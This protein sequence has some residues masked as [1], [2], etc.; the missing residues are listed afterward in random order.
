MT[1]DLP[2][3]LAA[4]DFQNPID[5]SLQ[6]SGEPIEP[7][8]GD[9]I[10][11]TLK[12]MPENATVM[13]SSSEINPQM[14]EENVT[15]TWKNYTSPKHGLSIEYPDGATIIEGRE[16]PYDPYKDLKILDDN[17]GF[18]FAVIDLNVMPSELEQFAGN[19]LDEKINSYDYET[20]II[21]IQ[22]I[23]PLSVNNRTYYTFIDSTIDRETD[24]SRGVQLNYFVSNGDRTYNFY[25]TVITEKMDST[26]EIRD[27]MIESIE[28][29]HQNPLDY[30]NS[31]A[32]SISSTDD[33]IVR[34]YVVN[35][36][37]PGKDSII[38]HCELMNKGG[39]NIPPKDCMYEYYDLMIPDYKQEIFK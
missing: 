24:K 28:F 5:P 36:D 21:P 18:S 4:D 30:L 39:L 17:S 8:N 7:S 34:D 10:N 31:T 2:E 20:Y 32:T 19:L 33:N 6:W 12:S 9:F 13:T 29:I 11:G 25:F 14:L 3:N 35:D 38:G 22:D 15:I 37:N 16:S 27:H 1:P 26:K 23:T